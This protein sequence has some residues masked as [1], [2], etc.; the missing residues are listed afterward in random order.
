MD[1][2]L[3]LRV[4][5]RFRLL[6]V[7]GTL[8]ALALTLLSIMSVS[9]EGGKPSLS[10]RQQETY[11]SQAKLLV[12]QRGFPWG[13][14]VFPVTGITPENGSRYVP[15]FA[16][17]SRFVSLAAFYAAL[18]NSD[19]VQ[20]LLYQDRTLR[21]DMVASPASDATVPGDAL[22]FIEIAGF[23]EDPVEAERMAV[24]G[25][26]AFVSYLTEQQEAATIPEAERVVVTIVNGA[27]PGSLF[28]GRKKTRPIATFL[29]VMIAI[30]GLA[31]VLE[32]LR[33][34]VRPVTV[35]EE[36]DDSVAA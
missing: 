34:R 21:G 7:L 2:G 28:E 3:H 25:T 20:A 35:V 9:F 1:L 33:P 17:P 27:D 31:F 13:R 8:L 23:A 10:Y 26:V 6:V 19:A 32:N 14:T 11:I 18:A 15:E 12:T 16:E 29:A 4:L 5:W 30:I 36:R 22:P 24:A